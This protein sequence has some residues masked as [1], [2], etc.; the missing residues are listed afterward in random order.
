[1]RY[2]RRALKAVGSIL[3]IA[4]K[5][6]YRRRFVVVTSDTSRLANDWSAIGSD[7]KNA[8]EKYNEQSRD[9]RSAIE[10]V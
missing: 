8:I 6:Q 10:S 2:K 1:M 9:E 4:P 3:D 7:L 5:G